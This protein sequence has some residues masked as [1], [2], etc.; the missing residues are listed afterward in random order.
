M[1]RKAAI[2][3]EGMLSENMFIRDAAGGRWLRTP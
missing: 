1:I 3:S 2:D